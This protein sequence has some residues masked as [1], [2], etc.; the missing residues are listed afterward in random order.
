[1][2]PAGL[3]PVNLT[4]SFGGHRCITIVK[5]QEEFMK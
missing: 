1:M 4:D 2:A 5:G 3:F